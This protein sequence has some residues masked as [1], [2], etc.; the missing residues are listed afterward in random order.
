MEDNE[1]E[2]IQDQN[3]FCDL[4]SLRE[5]YL[6]NNFLSDLNVNLTCLPQLSYINLSRNQIRHITTQSYIYGLLNSVNTEGD[7]LRLDLSDNP[8]ICDCNLQLYIEW[9]KNA[10]RRNPDRVYHRDRLNCY[11]GS[12][13]SNRDLHLTQVNQTTCEV[14]QIS[15]LHAMTTTLVWILSF[16]VIA[17]V[18]ALL[19]VQRKAVARTVQPLLQPTAQGVKY[20]SIEK[21]QEEGGEIAHV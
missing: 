14:L 3:L 5:I 15:N 19:F 9:V 4:T 18:V 16:M 21:A 8:F 12:P 10:T 7:E 11:D 1:I 6:A 13:A 17:L 20:T 2:L